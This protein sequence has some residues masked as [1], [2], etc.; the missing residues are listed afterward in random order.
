MAGKGVL[1]KKAQYNQ[2]VA[3]KNATPQ[4][5]SRINRGIL[6]PQNKKFIEFI[7]Y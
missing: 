2:R 6:G 5:P 4:G 1:Q 7:I 3:W